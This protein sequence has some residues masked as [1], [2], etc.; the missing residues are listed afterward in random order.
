[1]WPTWSESSALCLGSRPGIQSTVVC[2]WSSH[3][4]PLSSGDW[5]CPPWTP[6]PLAAS[7]W[8]YRCQS[9]AMCNRGSHLPRLLQPLLPASQYH[10]LSC[11][12][13]GIVVSSWFHCLCIVLSQRP[14]VSAVGLHNLH[15]FWGWRIYLLCQ[16]SDQVVSFLRCISCVME[17]FR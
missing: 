7:S 4:M 15:G 14:A 5:W 9:P 6:V 8:I 1:M 3:Q 13:R 10:I 16:L 11:R 2:A 17:M 12:H